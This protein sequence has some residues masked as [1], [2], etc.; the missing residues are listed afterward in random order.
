MKSLI[1]RDEG[2]Q[3]PIIVARA[4]AVG[5]YI[6]LGTNDDIQ[7]NAAIASLPAAG[8]VIDIK[9]GTYDIQNSLI[10]NTS[11]VDIRG[12]G[13]G[14]TKFITPSSITGDVPIFDFSNSSIDSGTSTNYNLASNTVP[15]DHAITLVDATVVNVGDW[16]LL[17]S[18]KSS[19][20]E[21]ANQNIGELHYVRSKSGN[22]LTLNDV[23]ND[24]YNTTDTAA[25]Y[26]LN[27]MM[28]NVTLSDLSISSAAST[29]ALSKGFLHAQFV[30]NLRIER[31]EMH[32][33]F[34]GMK[35]VSC[36]NSTIEGC[37][38]YK[39]DHPT[40]AGTTLR[41]GIW[42]AGATQNLTIEGNKFYQVRHAVTTGG[43]SGTYNNGVQRAITVTGNVSMQSDTA[44]FDTH[45]SV[46]GITFTG[47]TCIGGYEYSGSFAAVCGFQM[48]GK[49]ITIS[50]NIIEGIPGRGIMVFNG[51]AMA[52]APTA[53]TP[54][55]GGAVTVGT[56]YWFVTNV[57]NGLETAMSGPSAVQT[58]TS[59]NKT[60][61]LTLALGPTNTS[62][63]NIYRSTAGALPSAIPKLVA[64]ISDNTTTTYSDTTIDG[65]LGAAYDV[66]AVAVTQG[67]KI[68]DNEITG[69]TFSTGS[70]DGYG[71]YVD[72][73]GVSRVKICDNYIRKCQAQ[74]IRISGA[75][76]PG[77]PHDMDIGH[78]YIDN[79]PS[80]ASAS[81]HE[82]V[83][84][85]NS[86]RTS[87]VGNRVI[88]N[89]SHASSSPLAMTGTSDFW[90]ISDNYF[91]NNT[92]NIPTFVGTNNSITNN[93]GLN[94]IAS[95]DNGTQTSSVTIDRLVGNTQML[96]LGG[97]VA[98]TVNNGIV[99]GDTLTLMIIQDGTG[100]R[101]V[102]WSA[103]VKFALAGAPSL[104]TAA[105][106]VDIVNLLWD[107]TNWRESGR[108]IA[109][110]STLSDFGAPTAD[111][112]MASN[113]IT[114]LTNGSSSQ[115]AAAFGQIPTV[116]TAYGSVPAAPSSTAPSS[117]GSSAWAKGDHIHPYSNGF[118]AQDFGLLLWNY[119]IQFAGNSTIPA[120]AGT[121]QV[122]KIPVPVAT[123]ITNILVGVT[124]NGSSDEANCFAALFDGSKNLLA[125]TS[126]QSTA[127]KTQGVKQM[128][129]SSA[130]TVSP[131]YVYVAFWI[132]SA[133]TL[134]GFARSSQGASLN[135][136]LLS[137]T[138]SFFMTADTGK[139][140]TAPSSLGTFTA[141]NTAYWVGLS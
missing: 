134:P 10:I 17:Y 21:S 82:S 7:I 117:G 8:G 48:R 61:A 54:S 90:K 35:I 118:T 128:A 58:T 121:L 78:N 12:A 137:A 57:V 84:I 73:G 30:D 28:H 6:C 106:S 70:S 71:I 92:S 104:S 122:V 136:M 102:T 120:A 4:P 32:D 111:L 114:N 75:T 29:M 64:T 123:S 105:S 51:V 33:A 68:S 108:S 141:I 40:T 98:I 133:T 139:T 138:N 56:H 66:N 112:S 49:N 140:T 129:L 39:I 20:A 127:W 74:A 5:H 22:I 31:V 110:N 100:S 27:N 85:D 9:A 55:S 103:N 101:T 69:V 44:H 14:L 11:N 34:Y 50:D 1:Q 47:N 65:S 63:R 79:C 126:D 23:V 94:P 43:T 81:Q 77:S 15:G 26:R 86:Y 59:S 107:G 99:K 124:S 83:R 89:L 60:V 135:N 131:G 62:A 25:I 95:Y 42:A 115:D 113:K 125:Q 46:D 2:G 80:S 72:S 91:A 24:T 97:T 96:T 76:L 45:S 93:S 88:N 18:N 38:I 116:P 41:Y 37:S 130:Q 16:F 13:M 67:V 119:P 36:I 53:G 19:N 87:F 132:G 3:S 52:T 109:K